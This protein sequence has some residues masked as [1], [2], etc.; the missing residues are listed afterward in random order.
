M[1]NSFPLFA[2]TRWL[3]T[4]SGVLL[5][6]LQ[7]TPVLRVM[8][9]SE[10]ALTAPAA[11]LLRSLL[12][13]AALGAVHSLAGATTV[14][15]LVANTAQ[16]ARATVGASFIEGVLIQ[17]AGVSYAQSWAL[18]NTL[19]P[20]ISANGATLQ[21]GRLVINPSSGTLIFTGTPTTPGT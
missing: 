2:R 20:G 19:P 5:I 4:A 1:L 9:A 14:N 16:P 11:S 15:Q 10:T 21:G 18:S 12:P 17:G 6:L 13:A 8:L 3:N 7:R